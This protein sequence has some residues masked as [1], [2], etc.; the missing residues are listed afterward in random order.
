[1]LDLHTHILPGFDDG[2]KN[3]RQSLA[4]L[5]REAKQGVDRVVLTPHFYALRES[6]GAF[7]KRRAEALRQLEA[8]ASRWKKLPRRYTGAEVAYFSGISRI[9]DVEQLCIGNTRTMLVEMPFC[10]WNPRVLE[11][12]EY[13]KECRGIRPVIA[14]VE[15]YMRYQP[16]GTVRRLCESGFWIQANTSFFL[17][18][19]TS[20]LAMRMLKNREIHF[21]GTDCHDTK[22]RPP[23]FGEAITEIDRRLGKDALRY[24]RYMESRLLEGES[25]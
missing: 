22:R 17:E 6:P 25:H 13:L 21:I 14:H 12:L 15:R 1:M 3:V 20:W 23:N 18:W 2:S 8:E 10:R 16:M 9:E 11:E 19:Q 4:M 7:I 5:A 24:L